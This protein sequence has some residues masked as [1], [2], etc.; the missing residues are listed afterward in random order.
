MKALLWSSLPIVIV[1]LAATRLWVRRKI[2]EM[3]DAQ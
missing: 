1:L 3:E 2:A